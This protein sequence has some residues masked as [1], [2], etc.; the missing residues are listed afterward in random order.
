MH[1]VALIVFPGQDKNRVTGRNTLA[2]VQRVSFSA[3]GS[4]EYYLLLGQWHHIYSSLGITYAA[5]ELSICS[6]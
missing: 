4:F 3:P 1:S 5:A 2:H 6:P